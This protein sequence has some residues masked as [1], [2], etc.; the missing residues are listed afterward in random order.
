MPVKSLVS[1]LERVEAA[2][3]FTLTAPADI[4]DHPLRI[5]MLRAHFA[6]IGRVGAEPERWLAG[7][8]L[9]FSDALLVDFLFFNFD[10]DALRES[11]VDEAAVWEHA[12]PWWRA[13]LTREPE[14][15]A[16]AFAR[17]V[18]EGVLI[19]TADGFAIDETEQPA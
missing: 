19:E 11:G 6:R 1:R 17:W 2:L 12:L 7:I 18:E 16:P 8:V 14:A 9:G 3:H 5:A 4:L 15:V 13:A 10:N